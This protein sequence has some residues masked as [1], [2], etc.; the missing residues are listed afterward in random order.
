VVSHDSGINFQH[1]KA[2]VTFPIAD[3]D[4]IDVVTNCCADTISII[5]SC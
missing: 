4:K 5:A 1:L 2:C 3:E